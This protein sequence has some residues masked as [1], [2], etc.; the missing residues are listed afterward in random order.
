MRFIFRAD[1]SLRIGAGHVMRCSSVIEEALTRGIECVLAGNL[2]GIGWLEDYVA[3]LGV[4]H[5]EDPRTVQIMSDDVLILD[6]YEIPQNDSFIAKSNWHTIVTISDF[7]T[8]N[9]I[10][11][12]VIRLSLDKEF[13]LEEGP[14]CLSGPEFTPLR[15]SIQKRTL[16]NFEKVV[17]IVVFAGGADTFS[18]CLAMARI[19]GKIGDF[20]K[21]VFI[22]NAN[23]EI[24]SMDS[25]FY[26]EPF[27]RTLDFELNDADLVFTTASTSSLEIVAMEIPLGI[28]FAVDNQEPF[29][30]QLIRRKLAFGIGNLNKEGNW[31]LSSEQIRNLVTNSELR[32]EI[33]E[34]T[35]NFFD[36]K[37]SKRIVDE[38][39]K[40]WRNKR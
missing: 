1:S 39:L 12:L 36:L 34:N 17:K 14:V 29:Y 8:P 6:S 13:S 30:N 5:Y 38:I 24:V 22:T 4:V 27:G 18:L 33:A 35:R 40:V 15:K 21:A 16:N 11:D 2:G 23:E 19:L 10:S 3:R 31:N 9:Y 7:T 26:V 32:A 20:E 25:R 37:G 28:C